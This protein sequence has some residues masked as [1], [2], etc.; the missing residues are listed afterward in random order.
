MKDCPHKRV[1][2]CGH[3]AFAARGV[4]E[5]LSGAGH[6]VMCFSRGALGRNGSVVTGAVERIADNPHL[7]CPFD[8]V[9]NYILLKNRTIEEN[10]AYLESLLALCRRREAAHLIHFSSVSV[11]R[12]S[13][14]HVT[15]E[16][17]V[18]T[19]PRRKGSYGGLK[20]ATER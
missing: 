5:R 3:R 2:V 10:T 14:G 12:S 9:V 6:E 16:T 11:Y 1:L 15:E 18:E 8:T 7:D 17:R 4:V 19:D 20:I 13:I